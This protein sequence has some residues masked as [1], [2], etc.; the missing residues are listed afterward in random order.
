MENNEFKQPAFEP[1][2]LHIP[3]PPLGEPIPEPKKPDD[4]Q[5]KP[6]IDIDR[7][8]GETRRGVMTIGR[9]GKV[10]SDE[11]DREYDR[12]KQW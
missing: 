5:P 1:I 11:D 2:P 10:E 6:E 7:K 12:I 3:V 4:G 9:D 8:D